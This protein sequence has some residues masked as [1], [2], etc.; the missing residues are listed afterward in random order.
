MTYQAAMKELK[1]CGTAQNRKVYGRHGVKGEMFGV[2]FANLKAL[3]RKIKTDHE[4][5]TKLWESGNH[6]ARILAT[7]VADPERLGA[8]QLDAWARSLDNYVITDALAGLVARS[9]H[10]RAKADK[11][12]K[13]KD[14]HVGQLGWNLVS[15]FMSDRELYG[16][17]GEGDQRHVEHRFGDFEWF[18]DVCSRRNIKFIP[19]LGWDCAK[20]VPRGERL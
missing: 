11:W 20:A 4:L 15:W 8:G 16:I 14:D 1:S 3:A 5:A 6:D 18:L 7:M 17:V 10:A 9:K 2:S 13:S 19:M 12:G